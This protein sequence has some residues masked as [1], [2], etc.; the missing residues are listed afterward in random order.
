MHFDSISI[1]VKAHGK[2]QVKKGLAIAL[3]PVEQSEDEGSIIL[4]NSRIIIP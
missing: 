2:N 4:H 3:F 1:T